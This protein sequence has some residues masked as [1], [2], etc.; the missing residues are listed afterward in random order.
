[1]EGSPSGIHA[2]EERSLLA[3]EETSDP[4]SSLSF[5]HA[6]DIVELVILTTDE[7]FLQT[8]REAVGNTRRLWHVGS[9]DKVSDLL[10]AGEV[11]ILVLDAQSLQSAAGGFLSQI[12]R[13]FPDLVL[14]VAGSRDDEAAL[15]SLIS[16]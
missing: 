9:P 1:M 2:V 15:A 7:V 10:V 3:S 11:G 6:R 8:L 14:I 13:Q 4:I 5:S 16:T 12:K